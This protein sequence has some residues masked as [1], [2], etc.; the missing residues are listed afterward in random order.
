MSFSYTPGASESD[1]CPPA[2]KYTVLIADVEDRVAKSGANYL[3][4]KAQIIGPRFQDHTVT[5]MI[6]YEN[7]SPEAMKIGRRK[8][9]SLVMAVFG[10]DR[11]F[12]AQDLI[13]KVVDVNT[14][15]NSYN[16]EDNAR[17]KSYVGKVA[18]TVQPTA[19]EIMSKVAPAKGKLIE[20]M[21]AN[22]SEQNDS[23][24]PF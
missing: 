8:V 22:P 14:E 3:S 19:T 2:G 17:V 24:L 15:V 1:Q 5:D 16:G 10:E 4:I 9:R 20:T 11:P 7:S 12:V 18:Q 13:G 23:D 6:T 21:K